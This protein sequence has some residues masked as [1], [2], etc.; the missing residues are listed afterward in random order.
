MW[1]DDENSTNTPTIIAGLIISQLFFVISTVSSICVIADCIYNIGLKS[2]ITRLICFLNFSILLCTISR[3]PFLAFDKAV[4]TCQVVDALFWYGYFQIM[5]ICLKMFERSIS[6]ISFMNQ[7]V[8]D[9]SHSFQIQKRYMAFILILPLIPLTI[10]SSTSRKA[11]ST[12]ESIIFCIADRDDHAQR[13]IWQYES[14]G[15]LTFLSILFA[16]YY[17]F[18]IL[19]VIQNLS[20]SMLAQVHIKIF[21]GANIFPIIYFICLFLI[22]I[23]MAVILTNHLSD[24]NDFIITSIALSIYNTIGIAFS[25]AYLILRSDLKVS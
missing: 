20:D 23:C 8:F 9:Y 19:R 2:A 14:F 25:L 10:A 18:K 12:N 5:L 15:I 13:V 16:I 4:T 7:S 21:L 17:C 1:D 6:L 11:Y 24:T 22:N 3:F